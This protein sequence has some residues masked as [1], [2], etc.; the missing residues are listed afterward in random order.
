[1]VQLNESVRTAQIRA[2]EADTQRFTIPPGHNKHAHCLHTTAHS[3]GAT[4][5][6]QVLPRRKRWRYF[7][8]H[9]QRKNEQAKR[10][11]NRRK[12]HNNEKILEQDVYKTG[13]RRARLEECHLTKQKN[14]FCGLIGD[15]LSNHLDYGEQRFLFWP[16]VRN[17]TRHLTQESGPRSR[18]RSGLAPRLVPQ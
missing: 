18:T 4:V 1:M 13:L 15:F 8:S 11:W 5:A 12:T 2:F 10:Y 3:Y 7:G 17:K 6:R 14:N 9:A 16:A